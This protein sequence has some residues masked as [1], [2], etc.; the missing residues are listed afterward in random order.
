MKDDGKA[1]QQIVDRIKDVSNIL[2]TVSQDPSVDELA[3][4]LGLTLML[5]KM[6]K[7][8]TA[9]FSGTIP[10]AIDFLKPDKTFRNNVDNLRDFIVALDKEKADRLRYKVEDDLVRIFIT[11]YK[12]PISEE[13]LEYSYGDFN[14]E[15]VIALG[16][17]KRED[18]DKAITAHGRILH[19]ATVVTVNTKGSKSSLGSID[20]QDEEASSYCEMLMS[21]SEAL[22]NNL[23]DEQ[24]ANALLTGIVSATDRFSN[25]HTSPRVMTMAA[26]LMA[27]G[28]NQQLIAARLEEAEEISP[29]ETESKP[30]EELEQ[31]KNDGSLEIDHSKDEEER[32][33]ELD[34]ALSKNG[35]KSG[36]SGKLSLADIKKDLE[37]ASKEKNEEKD[38]ESDIKP[39]HKGRSSW[40]DK[41][42][43]PMIGGTL[44]ATAAE[45][46]EAKRREEQEARNKVIL[47]HG[48]TVKPPS[49]KEEDSEDNKTEGTTLAD[50]EAAVKKR[51]G[52]ED[53]KDTSES[54]DEKP[55]D[56][57]DDLPPPPAPKAEQEEPISSASKEGKPE[58]PKDDTAPSLP[59]VHDARKDVE[60]ALNAMPFNPANHP[61]ES[62]GAQPL[63]LPPPPPM[64]D[65]SQLPPPPP[66][67]PP[68]STPP[69]STPTPTSKPVAP[70]PIPQAN[71]SPM[72]PSNSAPAPSAS[73]PTQFR[74][75]GQ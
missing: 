47:K 50:L 51:D 68:E 30:E 23:L 36:D 64:P 66:M 60:D 49:E 17:E 43:P 5:N 31:T 6:D 37:E 67:V 58:V 73:D 15:L 59:D 65:F 28:A 16:V 46:E 74:I 26:Q 41:D 40:K 19:D 22:K 63:P 54:K 35:P 34:K 18:L 38:T 10:P 71:P 20:W 25:T 55:E 2:I 45:A 32:S 12:E 56:K 48:G 69:P 21:L 29:S 42:V 72:A 9:V 13:D 8:G 1:K 7:Y 39:E 52:K 27:A 44:N 62:I 11:P 70:P 3:A 33:D 75:P 4:A 53:P 14:V 57:N 24:I 61:A